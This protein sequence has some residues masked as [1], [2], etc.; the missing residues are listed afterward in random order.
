MVNLGVQAY[1]TDQ[2]LLRLKRYFDGFNVAVVIY[3][4]FSD[5]VKRNENRDRRLLVPA[6]KFMQCKV[7]YL[8]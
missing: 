5:H 6:G 4:Y 1:G 8:V 7:T 2:A 3:T